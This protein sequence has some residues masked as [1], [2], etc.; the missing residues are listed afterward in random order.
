MMF[1]SE[2]K[3]EN[4]IQKDFKI[5]VFAARDRVVHVSNVKRAYEACWKQTLKKAK[6]NYNKKSV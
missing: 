3:F 6:R 1:D 4:V 5:D 2:M